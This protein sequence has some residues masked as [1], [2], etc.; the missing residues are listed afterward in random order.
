ML[1]TQDRLAQVAS[2]LQKRKALSLDTETTGLKWYN[3]DRIVSIIIS[4]EE[5]DYY[6]NFKEYDGVEALDWAVFIETFN[7]IFLSPVK[8]WYLHNAKF[9]LHMLEREGIS[10][11][12]PIHDTMNVERLLDNNVMGLSLEKV[13]RRYGVR[14][15]DGVMDWLKENKKYELIQVPGKQK[16]ERV[17]DW[18]SVP[19][20]ILHPY[21]EQDGRITFQVGSRQVM[22]CQE[23]FNFQGDIIN[24]FRRCY[25]NEARL[26]KTVFHMEHLGVRV[27][28]PYCE[29]AVAYYNA[30]LEKYLAEYKDKTGH[31]FVDSSKA[32]RE[33]V[34]EL[35]S[36]RASEKTG[37]PSYDNEVLKES[38]H[39]M[40]SLILDLRKTK[41]YLDFFNG[42]L[43][44]A[45]DSGYLH[46]SLNQAGTKT[47]RFSCSSPNLQQLTKDELEGDEVAA[48]PVRRGIVPSEGH[49]FLLIDYD[50]QEYRMM[51]DYCDAKALIK[52]I[53]G[54]LDVHTATAEDASVYVPIT[55]KQAKTVN[56]GIL[57]GQ[58]KK[59]LARGL[60]VT[61]TEAMK[62]KEAIFKSAPSMKRFIHRVTEKARIS[63]SIRNWL[64]RI[65]YYDAPKEGEKDYYYRAPNALIQGGCADVVKVAM[66]ECDEFLAPYKSRLVMCIHD[67][68]VFEVIYGEEFLVP[69]LKEIMESVYRHRT[70]PMTATVE[71]SEHSLADR[72]EWGK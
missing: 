25:D 35:K 6:F 53:K 58:G 63:G 62:I 70:L 18:S 40:A 34:P 61:V 15:S 30:E 33:A 65:C 29:D 51:L 10:L 26:I 17:Y 49:F 55:R 21:G 31:D 59:A 57:Y 16:R 38:L 66:N 8:L 7:P 46:A 11:A 41:K 69:R 14:K 24:P 27:D 4:D 72:K 48:Y 1:V 68:L 42:F 5:K 44:Y 71:Y 39:P 28:I 13:S 12:G 45:S 9:D 43:Y 64:G 36:K 52:K 56:F 67:E 60:G 32:F 20:D 37:D 50:Q 19:F 2:F 23:I 47:G 54:G 22:R 3:E